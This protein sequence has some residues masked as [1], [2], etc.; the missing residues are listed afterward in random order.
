MIL[1]CEEKATHHTK[2]AS[3]EVGVSFFSFLLSRAC[4]SARLFV[5]RHNKNYTSFHTK[6]IQKPHLVFVN[7]KDALLIFFCSATP[8][9]VDDQWKKNQKNQKNNMSSVSLIKMENTISRLPSLPLL[10]RATFKNGNAYYRTI[11]PRSFFC[12]CFLQ[13]F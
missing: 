9:R 3:D 10:S 13:S 4:L 6:T 8:K 11:T 2:K 12:C 7:R 5:R 1:A